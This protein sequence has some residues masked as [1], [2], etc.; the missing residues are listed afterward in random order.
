MAR[1]VFVF[2]DAHFPW[3]DKRAVSRAIKELGKVNKE[4]KGKLIIVQIGDLYDLFSFSRFAR[5]HNLMTPMQEIETARTQAEQFW[6]QVHK[7]APGSTCYQLTGNHDVRPMRRALEIMPAMEHIVADHMKELMTFQGVATIHNTREELE[8]G[9]ILYIHGYK[10]KLGDHARYNQCSVVCGH[11]H[12]G[13]TVFIPTFD[14]LIFE[15]N[16]GY[17][18]DRYSEALS[19]TAQKRMTTWT[20]GLGIIDHLGPR[21][22]P[23]PDT[24]HQYPASP[25]QNL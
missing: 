10:T 25:K 6:Q 22:V 8:I 2:G 5:S 17:L 21:F 1:T 3:S 11:S 15:L 24:F 14:N 19:Y 16:V 9:N 23:L 12:R 4:T 7:A 13:G 20:S 18:G